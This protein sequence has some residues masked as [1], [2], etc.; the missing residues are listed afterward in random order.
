MTIGEVSRLTGVTIRTL[1]YYDRIGLLR[2]AQITEAG[3]RIYDEA[4]LQR[5]HTILLFREL[6]TPLEDIRRILDSPDFDPLPALR[7]QQTLLRMRRQHI[8][9]LIDL[10]NTLMQKGM[11]HMDFS[12]FDKRQMED[13][14]RQAKAAWGHTDAWQDYTSR[15]NTRQPGDSAVYGQQL[16]ALLGQFGRTR[17]VSPDHPESQA[18]VG[19]MQTFITDHFYAC[20]DEALLGL[21]DLYETDRFRR[22]IDHAGGEGTAGFLAR[23]IRIR[24]AEQ[25]A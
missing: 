5:L 6:E 21:A 2:P 9:R 24:L 14:A 17:P 23:A 15:E 3:Y 10:T 11:T 22:R 1:R 20:T 13:Y 12:A 7:M 25:D 8:D 16:M 18:F 4:A 19:Q